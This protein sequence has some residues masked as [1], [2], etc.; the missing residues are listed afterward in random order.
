[1]DKGK[2]SIIVVPHDLKKTRTVRIPYALFYAIVGILAAGIAVMIVFA[3]TYGALLLKVQEGRMYKRQLE[4]LEK[5]QV[6]IVELRRNVAQLRSMNL[7]V[8]R[9]LGLVVTPGDSAAIL[10]VERGNAAV[11]EGLRVE[12]AAMLRAIPTFWPVRGFITNRFSQAGG[13]KD[14][15]F[16]G[17]IDIAVDRGTPV[18]AAASGYASE[19]GWNDSYGYYVQIDH[20]YGIKTLYAH[21]DMLVVSKGERV[22]QGQTI[23][24]SGNTGRSTAPHLHFQ[25]T[26]NNIP[27]DPLKYLLQ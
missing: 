14:T 18:R 21:A 7:Q 8:R 26:Q 13:E 6:Q 17:G 1:M 25:V 12:Q 4:E 2:F 10:Q 3:A 16:H 19:A 23:A 22:A 15:I 20:G 9:M 11:P 5:R 24:Y 27:V